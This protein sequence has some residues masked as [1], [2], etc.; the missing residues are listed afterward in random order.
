VVSRPPAAP[1]ATVAAMPLQQV[2]P[3]DADLLDACGARPGTF[4][5][6]VFEATGNR[7]LAIV[8]DWFIGRP[9]AIVAIL[10]VAWILTRLARRGLRRFIHRIV[11]TDRE[12]V[13]RAR[14]LV[15]VGAETVVQDPR[16][17][18]RA[19]SISIVL[20]S[21]VAVVV[22]VVAVFLV[23]SQL[24]INLAPLLASAG[25]A[26]V[27]LGFGAQSLVKDCIT[28]LF[29][30]IEDQYGI[31]DVVD[32]GE[33]SGSVERISLR[34]TVLR[35]V[36][37]TIW[38][39]PNG[40]IRRVGNR[41]QLW[42]VAIIDAVIGTDADIELARSTMEAAVIR[43]CEAEEF[44][45]DVLEPPEVLGVESVGAEGVTLRAQVRTPPGA[46]LRLARALRVAVK[47]DLDAVGIVSPPPYRPQW[48]PT[49]GEQP[50]PT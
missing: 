45:G 1:L 12:A 26:G 14:Q 9:L 35:S 5:E 49:A 29:M 25:I 43:V 38:H 24:G 33:A 41:S 34:T 36:D 44:A 11:V 28:G 7:T 50:A 48:G 32:V 20:G 22:W 16:R 15:G 17:A 21:A 6:V 46:Q 42:S 27:A 4:C 8:A 30:L 23:L 37:G 47:Q 19:Q 13:S 31:G 40:E 10:A 2:P 3:D 18:G 39:V